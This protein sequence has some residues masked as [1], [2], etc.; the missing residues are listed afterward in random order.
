MPIRAALVSLKLRP[1][2]VLGLRRAYGVARVPAGELERAR[3]DEPDGFSG[4][5]RAG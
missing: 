2:G 1:T 3:R 4:S 5:G